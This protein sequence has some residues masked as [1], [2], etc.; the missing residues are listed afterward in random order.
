MQY[1]IPVTYIDLDET[2]SNDKIP[3]ISLVKN[4]KILKTFSEYQDQ[5]TIKEMFENN[6][7]ILNETTNQNTDSNS[8]NENSDN[9]SNTDYKKQENIQDKNEN[10]STKTDNNS[11]DKKDSKTFNNNHYE[12]L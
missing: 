4:G 1:K 5:D 12:A 2:N 11:N 10:D 3:S 9:N 7:N 8:T 6:K